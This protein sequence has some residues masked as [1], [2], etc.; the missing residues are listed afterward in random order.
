[1]CQPKI[2][3]TKVDKLIK[4]GFWEGLDYSESD[5]AS[6]E[7]EN[8]DKASD[9][10][11]SNLFLMF[12]TMLSGLYSL[13]YVPTIAQVLKETRITDTAVKAFA[14][15]NETLNHILRWY[16]YSGED[17]MKSLKKVRKLHDNT[18]RRILNIDGGIPVSQHDL[19]V[20]Q[21]AFIGPIL[22]MPEGFGFSNV[23]DEKLHPVMQ[24]MYCVGREL[25]IKNE[26]NVCQGTVQD[27]RAYAKDILNEI[28]VPNLSAKSDPQGLGGPLIR[29]ANILNP[30]IH[31]EA[32]PLWIKQTY[33]CHNEDS[34]LSWKGSL[35]LAFLNF[36]FHYLLYFRI[37]RFMFLWIF[38]LLMRLNIFLANR[39][40]YDLIKI[41]KY[42]L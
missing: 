9:F 24:L 10:F 34:K 15:Y 4:N 42:S 31:P 29:G 17:R 8:H 30:L 3:E 18:V 2:T 1:M 33:G 32:F 28:I 19:V 37:S 22:V 11:H 12:V 41:N 35:I 27:A 40:K 14:R 38:N 23:S 25:G 21:W 39:W 26:Y 5:E 7:V 16:S 13:L 36:V 20:T 6:G